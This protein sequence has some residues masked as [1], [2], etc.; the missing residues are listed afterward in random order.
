VAG[1]AVAS[2][3]SRASL[4]VAAL[5]LGSLTSSS[6]G[7]RGSLAA[8]SGLTRRKTIR[9]ATAPRYVAD[10]LACRRGERPRRQAFASA[11][12]VT[13]AA[14]VSL[15]LLVLAL[16]AGIVV[17]AGGGQPRLAAAP[18]PVVLILAVG[19]GNACQG[20]GRGL[21]TSAG[22][23]RSPSSYVK[24]ALPLLAPPG[25]G[26]RRVRLALVSMARRA[27]VAALRPAT[28][29][30]APRTPC[31]TRIHAEALAAL[32]EKEEGVL[33]EGARAAFAGP[34]SVPVMDGCSS[35][36]RGRRGHGAAR[37]SAA[38]R[39]RQVPVPAGGRR[40]RGSAGP[41]G[42]EPT[43]SAGERRLEALRELAP[44]ARAAGWCCPMREGPEPHRPGRLGMLA[45]D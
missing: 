26:R 9:F 25:Q 8:A 31:H 10:V 11:A 17:R 40:R 34:F 36:V 28:A 12:A 32:R 44:F 14:V 27:G 42:G 39:R 29:R 4:V 24:R 41:A 2:P 6:S 38:G 23:G 15:G 19:G 21:T 33:F 16:V 20:P 35:L 5:C 22:C 7:R 37:A 3:S 43:A 1:A 45:D 18:P 30:S 13:A